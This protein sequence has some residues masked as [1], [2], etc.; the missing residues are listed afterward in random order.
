MAFAGKGTEAKITV[1]NEISQTPEDKCVFSPSGI[2]LGCVSVST[3]S[4]HSP[5]ANHPS[6]L[7]LTPCKHMGYIT[8]FQRT[9]H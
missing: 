5:T 2:T 6:R 9:P 4:P 1:L 7:S 8:S 3:T